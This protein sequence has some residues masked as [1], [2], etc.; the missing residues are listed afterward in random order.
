MYLSFLET[1]HWEEVTITWQLKIFQKFP[2]TE[3]RVRM[4]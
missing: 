1:L 4:P 3:R 2:L